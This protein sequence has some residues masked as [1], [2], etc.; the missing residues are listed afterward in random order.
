MWYNV[1][2]NSENMRIHYYQWRISYIPTTTTPNFN[3]YARRGNLHKFFIHFLLPLSHHLLMVCTPTL[4]NTCSMKVEWR[5][6]MTC[7]LLQCTCSVM[8]S[9]CL[10]AQR[11]IM[12]AVYVFN[13]AGGRSVCMSYSSI[14]GRLRDATRCTIILFICLFASKIFW[15]FLSTGSIDSPIN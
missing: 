15:Q 6:C 2:I 12:F 10:I 14:C 5:M 3:K 1:Q 8:I 4:L 9:E 11:Y 7:F 13:I